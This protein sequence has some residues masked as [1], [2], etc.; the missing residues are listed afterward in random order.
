[1]HHALQCNAM[2]ASA[3]IAIRLLDCVTCLGAGRERNRERSRC[4][5]M[6]FKSAF[7]GIKRNFADWKPHHN[8]VCAFAENITFLP[9]FKG[10]ASIMFSGGGSIS[11]FRPCRFPIDLPTA[12]PKPT[13]RMQ[14]EPIVHQQQTRTETLAEEVAFS[15]EAINS[16]SANLISSQ[17]AAGRVR[18]S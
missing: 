3:E 7:R 5:T 10:G 12:P 13:I 16:H 2:K 9:S 4:N 17:R 18:F 1:M 15:P 11:I 8:R 6:Q 14:N